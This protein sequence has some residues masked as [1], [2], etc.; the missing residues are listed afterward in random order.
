MRYNR[1]SKI[2]NKPRYILLHSLQNL[3]Q[4][5]QGHYGGLMR[6]LFVLFMACY[7]LLRML[8][9]YIYPIKSNFTHLFELLSIGYPETVSSSSGLCVCLNGFYPTSDILIR[10]S[11]HFSQK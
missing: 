1:Y 2:K 10:L 7:T 11:S 8:F 9:R 6:T 5:N 4:E 3:Q